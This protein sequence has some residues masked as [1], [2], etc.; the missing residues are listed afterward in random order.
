MA[1]THNG[2]IFTVFMFTMLTS[3]IFS[4]RF[5]MLVIFP[6]P[7][8]EEIFSEKFLKSIGFKLV[9]LKNGYGKAIDIRTNGMTTLQ[10]NLEGASC[11]YF[12]DKLKPNIY[13]GILKDAGTRYAFNGYIYTRE[14]V[15]RLLVL[16]L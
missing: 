16:T 12:G 10:W 6:E 8:K 7:K 13:L 3:A 14:D 9:S 4:L 1:T 15:I 11:T 2:A 5:L